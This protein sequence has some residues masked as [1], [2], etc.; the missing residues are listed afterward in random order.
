M[1][2]LARPVPQSSAASTDPAP[3]FLATPWAGKLARVSFGSQANT[4]PID[5]FSR[6]SEQK[7]NALAQKSV[8]PLP[9]ALPLAKGVQALLQQSGITE[10]ELRDWVRQAYEVAKTTSKQNVNKLPEVWGSALVFQSPALS[11]ILK[12]SI[13]FAPDDPICSE[14]LAL[15]TAM[16]VHPQAP[17]KALVTI[18][19]RYAD[20]YLATQC[21]CHICQQ[22]MHNVVAQN[23]TLKP[24]TLIGY[25]D[26][27]EKGVQ[28]LQAK[29]LKAL[30]PLASQTCDVPPDVPA[31]LSALPV[32]IS[33]K[34]QQVMGSLKPNDVIAALKQAQSAYYNAVSFKRSARNGQYA[35]A[36]LLLHPPQMP[37]PVVVASAS[38]HPKQTTP[39]YADLLAASEALNGQY[40]ELK[41]TNHKLLPGLKLA[42]YFGQPKAD[43]P[44]PYTLGQLF[45]LSG[46]DHLLVTTLEAGKIRVRT[47]REWLPVQYTKTPDLS[48]PNA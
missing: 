19:S 36:A 5:T 16:Q 28:Q 29:P 37:A 35:G 8:Q 12:T 27:D 26:R 30:F 20:P 4:Q 11:P 23:S 13:A 2:L 34:A 43:M 24:D 14:R 44:R 46:N 3:L 22:T 17:V 21:A 9:H 15:K 40:P 48:L 1:M 7:L 47:Q 6:L 38:L 45:K 18:T 39:M 25:I 31:D 33:P 42:A 41:S 10:P 32:E